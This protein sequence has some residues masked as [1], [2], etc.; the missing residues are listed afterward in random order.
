MSKNEI[1]DGAIDQNTGMQRETS[2]SHK[3]VR[4]VAFDAGIM[5]G[6]EERSRVKT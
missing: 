3:Q 2:V 6:K 4:M 5:A 1:Y